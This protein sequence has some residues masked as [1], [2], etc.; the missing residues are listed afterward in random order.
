MLP[1]SSGPA[2]ARHP[3][4]RAR[5][6]VGLGSLVVTAALAVGMAVTQRLADARS[7]AS[8]TGGEAGR[9]LRD[10]QEAVGEAAPAGEVP[11]PAVPITRSGAS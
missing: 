6:A 11:D 10:G 7:G 8:A 4:R 1:S 2:A 5:L 9:I 3:A